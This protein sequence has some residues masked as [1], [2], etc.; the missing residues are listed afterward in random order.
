MSATPLPIVIFSY[1]KHSGKYVPANHRY[2]DYLLKDIEAQINDLPTADG[3]RY[4]SRRLDILLQFLY[5]G[6][7]KEGWEF[8]DKSYTLPDSDKIKAKVK[9]VLRKAPAYNFI[10]KKNSI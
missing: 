1:D 9:E 6:K 4:L 8:F 3:E 5:A 10:R 7:E 2:R